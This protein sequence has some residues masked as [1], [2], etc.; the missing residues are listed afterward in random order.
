M[1][2]LKEVAANLEVEVKRKVQ[3]AKELTNVSPDWIP[4]KM[5]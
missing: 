2:L 5:P 1:K 4:G 3:W